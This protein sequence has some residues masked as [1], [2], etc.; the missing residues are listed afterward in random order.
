MYPRVPSFSSSCLSTERLRRNLLRGRKRATI[1]PSWTS[2]EARAPRR[3]GG[4]STPGAAH[5]LAETHRERKF[6]SVAPIMRKARILDASLSI[7][8]SLYCWINGVSLIVQRPVSLT[9]KMRRH[10]GARAPSRSCDSSAGATLA[11]AW[12]ASRF[13]SNRFRSDPDKRR[14]VRR[15][16]SCKKTGATGGV[17]P[18]RGRR[19]LSRGSA[20]RAAAPAAGHEGRAGAHQAWPHPAGIGVER[21]P[22]PGRVAQVERGLGSG[23]GAE[24]DRGLGRPAIE[25][26]LLGDMSGAERA[27]RTERAERAGRTRRA[28]RAAAVRAVT[29]SAVALTAVALARPARVAVDPRS[30]RVDDHDRR[31]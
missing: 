22:V 27:V 31:D 1:A 16:R 17:A 5:S 9:E 30:Y 18:V 10:S 21:R 4:C 15:V 7:A 8:H 24:V 13:N 11:R 12:G 23:R 14:G 19:G 28:V 29:L 3:S 6:G 26:R 25:D 20:Q 2:G